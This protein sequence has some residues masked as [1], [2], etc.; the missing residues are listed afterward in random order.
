MTSNEM[1]PFTGAPEVGEL[2]RL[3]R[4]KAGMSQTQLATNLGVSKAAVSSWEAGRFG[5]RRQLIQKL[6]G[7]LHLQPN[8]LLYSGPD[9]ATTTLDV[10][11]LALILT[12]VESAASKR[13]ASLRPN[14]RAKLISHLYA[15]ERHHSADELMAL[16]A[17]IE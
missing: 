13:F 2:I 14:Q 9:A 16:I 6:A 4:K 17:L 3:H 10:D 12:L 15:S 7:L 1:R 8:Q 5:V 11:R